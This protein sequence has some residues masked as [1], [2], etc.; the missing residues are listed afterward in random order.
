VSRV[1]FGLLLAA[2]TFVITLTVN[3]IKRSRRR[4]LALASA[5]PL[6]IAGMPEGERV[7]IT[8]VVGAREPLITSPAGHRC[9]GFRMVIQRG[10]DRT[11]ELARREDCR[12]FSLTDETGAVVVDGPFLLALDVDDGAWG[13]PPPSVAAFLEEE[14]GKKA[15]AFINGEYGI[16]FQEA[17]LK[18]GD[19]VTVV[20][21]ATMEVDPAARGSHRDPPMINHI[22]GSEKEPVVV[23]DVAEV[24]LEKVDDG[25][26]TPA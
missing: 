25:A 17:V 18:P 19:R 22:R 11:D 15:G 5:T 26:Q 1:L 7:K 13:N 9:I 20:G 14:I 4:A 2:G 10:N 6:A 21:S 16:R 8:G 12:S 3:L 23:S 24:A